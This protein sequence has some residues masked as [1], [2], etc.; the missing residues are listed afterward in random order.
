M[1]LTAHAKKEIAKWML[2]RGHSFLKSAILLKKSGGSFDVVL[3]NICQ[4]IEVTLKAF[5][6]FKDY[7]HYYPLLPKKKHF[8]HDLEKLANEV[9]SSN[10]LKPLSAEESHEIL[11]LN[12]YY[13][14]QFLRYSGI[15]DIF[16]PSHNVEF[17]AIVKRLIV[18]IRY[19]EKNLT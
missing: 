6:L 5:L 4:G 3:Y 15:H 9:I 14:N 12:K 11:T 2:V 8:G 13:T 16:Y 17:G 7:D 1:R 10:S 19:A 18:A